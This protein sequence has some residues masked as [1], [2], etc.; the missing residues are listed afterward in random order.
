MTRIFYV[1]GLCLLAFNV[2][3]VMPGVVVSNQLEQAN[4]S[5]IHFSKFY[6]NFDESS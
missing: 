2:N 3:D 4:K 6:K 1:N 5:G